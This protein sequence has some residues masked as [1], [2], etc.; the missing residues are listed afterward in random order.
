[1]TLPLRYTKIQDC[2]DLK[3]RG[4]S[5]PS[6]SCVDAPGGGQ[7]CEGAGTGGKYSSC[8]ECLQNC[9]NDPGGKDR[10]SLSI[11]KD[12]DSFFFGST[13][14]KI[15]FVFLILI[16]LLILINLSLYFYRR[17]SE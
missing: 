12:S 16:G 5:Y 6:Y 2:S 13:G 15:I 10:S 3:K 17:Y 11:T 9:S 4:Q 8:E 14:G 7:E 1:M